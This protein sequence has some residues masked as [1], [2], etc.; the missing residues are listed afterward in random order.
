MRVFERTM[1]FNLAIR[2][3]SPSSPNLK[4]EGLF[5]NAD[6][7]AELVVLATIVARACLS[8]EVRN[9]LSEPL[10][11]TSAVVVSET[12]RIFKFGSLKNI[13]LLEEAAVE[14]PKLERADAVLHGRGKSD[15]F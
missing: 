7:T 6:S 8:T 9:V 11:L 4:W 15:C 10:V 2:K 12:I 1:I 14:A 5:V 13:N 3:L